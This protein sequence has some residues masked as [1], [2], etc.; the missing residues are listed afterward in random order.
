VKAF[1]QLSFYLL[2]EITHSL[3]AIEVSLVEG[4]SKSVSRRAQ[5]FLL[6]GNTESIESL[7][8]E[9]VDGAGTGP[10]VVRSKDTLVQ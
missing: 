7:V 4:A 5:T 8:N 9:V 6:E 3:Q 2:K 10:D 1:N